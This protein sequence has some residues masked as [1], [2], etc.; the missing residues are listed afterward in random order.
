MGEGG[1]VGLV[2]VAGAMGGTRRKKMALMFI[3]KVIKLWEGGREGGR[4]GESDGW[5]EEGREEWK[6]D[7]ELLHTHTAV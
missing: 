7:N 5:R 4:S 1:G 2:T 3:E 6:I